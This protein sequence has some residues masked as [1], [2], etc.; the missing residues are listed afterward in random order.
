MTE[1]F[2]CRTLLKLRFG[3]VFGAMYFSSVYLKSGTNRL[4]QKQFGMHKSSTAYQP[5]SDGEGEKGRDG[6]SIPYIHTLRTYCFYFHILCTLRRR[7]RRHRLRFPFRFSFGTA[8]LMWAFCY[9]FQIFIVKRDSINV[10]LCLVLPTLQHSRPTVLHSWYGKPMWLYNIIRFFARSLT[11]SYVRSVGQ[12]PYTRSYIHND[13]NVH[14]FDKKTLYYPEYIRSIIWFLSH[15]SNTIAESMW[16]I[17]RNKSHFYIFVHYAAATLW[18]FTI[19]SVTC[20]EAHPNF[21][22]QTFVWQRI[23][24]ATVWKIHC[25]AVGWTFTSCI[26]WTVVLR[27]P[28][29]SKNIKFLLLYV[30]RW[31]RSW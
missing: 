16:T 22:W 8:I 1:K 11:P 24:S 19:V 13:Q 17:M 30:W 14:R 3:K 29:H 7:R 21:K 12:I 20:H 26:S 4:S 6:A 9:T 18:L 10:C 27:W 31:P 15:H 28:F 2:D 25:F 23:V 5:R